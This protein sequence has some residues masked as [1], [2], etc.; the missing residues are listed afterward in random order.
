[1]SKWRAIGV[2]AVAIGAMLVLAACGDDDETPEEMLCNEIGRLET[3]VADLQAMDLTA[4]PIGDIREQVDAVL[5]AMAAVGEARAGVGE[6]R[7]DALQTAVSALGDTIAS[8]DEGFSIQDIADAIANAA[9][10]IDDAA[11]ELGQE[12]NCS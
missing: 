9:Q 5:E 10:G 12:V 8:L 2:V 11:A 4:A 6:A 7:I 1:L 3:E